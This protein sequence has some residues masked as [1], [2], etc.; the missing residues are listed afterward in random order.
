MIAPLRS[1]CVA[2]SIIALIV[3]VPARAAYVLQA[4]EHA[5]TTSPNVETTP[6]LGVDAQGPFVVYTS[7]EPTATGYGPGSILHQRLAADGAPIGVPVIVS[8]GGTDDQLNDVHGGKIA[9]TAFD[10]TTSSGGKIVLYDVNTGGR[11]VLAIAPAIREP[12]I[13]GD[14][15]AWIQGAAGATTLYLQNVTVGSAPVAIA[16]PSPAATNVEIGERFVVW[17]QIAGN[18]RDVYAYDLASGAVRLLAA[19]ELDERFPSTFGPWV[20]YEAAGARPDRL[21]HEAGHPPRPPLRVEGQG[22]AAQGR[23]RTS[24]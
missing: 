22:H 13:H 6:T 18:H 23:P 16:G 2:S 4:T 1:V 3:A 17:D 7:R 21:R 12:R 19:T 20:V 5:I 8:A 10:S 15:V 24:G 11:T 14:C 9:F